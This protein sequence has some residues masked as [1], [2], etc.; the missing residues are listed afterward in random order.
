MRLPLIKCRNLTSYTLS[1]ES[2]VMLREVLSVIGVVPIRLD[3]VL[4]QHR[5]T[6]HECAALDAMLAGSLSSHK[7]HNLSF[8][9]PAVCQQ[10]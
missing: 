8:R 2:A 9:K 1:V 3:H 4:E 10:F 6:L 7:K 5:F